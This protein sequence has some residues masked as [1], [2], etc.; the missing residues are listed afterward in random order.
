MCSRLHYP[1]QRNLQGGKLN[2]AGN[3]VYGMIVE[4]AGFGCHLFI[5]GTGFHQVTDGKFQLV[6]LVD[7][8]QD[9]QAGLGVEIN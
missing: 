4:N 3:Q 9:G 1:H 5:L 2:A 7:T 8:V 6:R